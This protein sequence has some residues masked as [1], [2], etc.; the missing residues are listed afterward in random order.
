MRNPLQEL[1]RIYQHLNISGF[2]ECKPKFLSY[3][4]TQEQFQQ[5]EFK[6]PAEMIADVNRTCGF[7]FD[8]WNYQRM[9]EA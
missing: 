1:E 8:A 7:A 3:L 5:N 4:K 6:M 2:E 9:P